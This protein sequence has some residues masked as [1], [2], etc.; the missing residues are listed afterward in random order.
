MR[1]LKVDGLTLE[2]PLNI[3]Q[4]GHVLTLF[5]LGLETNKK[6][7]IPVSGHF[8]DAI[9]E[10]MAKVEKI[11]T[12]NKNKTTVFID[13]HFVDY[14]QEEWTKIYNLYSKHQDE[15]NGLVMKQNNEREK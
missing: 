2:I 6:L 13:L 15:I 5:F 7:N 10:A 11:E 14:E 8:K 3:C 1:E 4:K 9:L 12:N